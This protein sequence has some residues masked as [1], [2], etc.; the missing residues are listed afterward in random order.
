MFFPVACR[1]SMLSALAFVVVLAIIG[2][3]FFW[4]RQSGIDS[5]KKKQAIKKAVGAYD[6]AQKWA[7]RPLNRNDAVKRLRDRSKRKN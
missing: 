2:A 3:A 1:K 5:E 4:S 6:E 7:N